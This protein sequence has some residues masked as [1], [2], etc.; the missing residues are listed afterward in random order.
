M[1]TAQEVTWFLGGLVSITVLVGAGYK[2]AKWANNEKGYPK[3]DLDEKMGKKLDMSIFENQKELC[4]HSFTSI[5]EKLEALSEEQKETRIEQRERDENNQRIMN[6]II[7][8]LAEK[9]AA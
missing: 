9:K 2:L 8:L 6:R 3:T 4:G 1:V 5:H 7:D